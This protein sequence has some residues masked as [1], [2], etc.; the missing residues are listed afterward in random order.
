MW[1]KK[2]KGGKRKYHSTTQPFFEKADW[3]KTGT[4]LQRMHNVSK[5]HTGGLR[6]GWGRER[7]GGKKKRKG[8]VYRLVAA[9]DC[10][11]RAIAAAGTWI[12]ALARARKE[13]QQNRIRARERHG[14]RK[15]GGWERRREEERAKR[16]RGNRGGWD[17]WAVIEWN[18]TC[19]NVFSSYPSYQYAA[20]ISPRDNEFLTRFFNQSRATC[21][22]RVVH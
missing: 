19:F 16:W 4:R 10:N 22:R 21:K 5:R 8:Q 11:G 17:W 6:P 15:R 9:A 1:Q 13:N 2:K 14:E 12:R 18:F 7:V 20:D 3:R